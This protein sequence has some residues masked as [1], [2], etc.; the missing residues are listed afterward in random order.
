[1]VIRTINLDQFAEAFPTKTRLM[2]RVA[3]F[4]AQP[5]PGVLHPLAQRLTQN[6]HTMILGQLLS[7]K[8]GPEIDLGLTN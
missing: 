1:M 7:C 3:P 2:E 6:L 8:R 4:A 5:E